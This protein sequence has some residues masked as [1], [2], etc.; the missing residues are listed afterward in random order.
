MFGYV[1]LNR[2][3]FDA[4]DLLSHQTFRCPSLSME[5]TLITLDLI[6]T[7]TL[8]SHALLN[9]GEAQY[10]GGIAWLTRRLKGDTIWT[11][12]LNLTGLCLI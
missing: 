11:L 1:M 2:I 5:Q 12:K 10:I 9:V 4:Y 3:I 8:N 7:N 6:E